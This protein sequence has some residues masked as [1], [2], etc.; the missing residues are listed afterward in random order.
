M[1][2]YLKELGQSGIDTV[3]TSKGGQI[4]LVTLTN[5]M[6]LMNQ[7][8]APFAGCLISITSDGIRVLMRSYLVKQSGWKSPTDLE[9]L[10]LYPEDINRKLMTCLRVSRM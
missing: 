6:T 10:S 4:L 7:T 9:I 5:P 8:L 1:Q 3:P 2:I